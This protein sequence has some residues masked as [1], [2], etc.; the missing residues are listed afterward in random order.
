MKPQE[1]WNSTYRE[2]T[3]FIKANLI[4][5]TDNYR[6]QIR[7]EEESTNKL[8]LADAMSQKRPKIVSLFKTF[9]NLFP[10]IKKDSVQS[11]E[12]ITKRMRAI[13]KNDKK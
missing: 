5:N 13:M 11:S 2:I 6:Q 9:K 7:L 4:K 8:I 3:V 1:Y 10:E 12:E